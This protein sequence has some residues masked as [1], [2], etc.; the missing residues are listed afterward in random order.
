MD[1]ILLKQEV[2]AH[3]NV[4]LPELPKTQRWQTVR[5]TGYTYE[6]AGFRDFLK[7]LKGQYILVHYDFLEYALP[8]SSYYAQMNPSLTA[9]NLEVLHELIK[10]KGDTEL[11][12]TLIPPLYKLAKPCE[13]T[14]KQLEVV[15][16]I[17]SEVDKQWLKIATLCK[18]GLKEKKVL[19]KSGVLKTKVKRADVLKYLT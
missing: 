13:L 12:A 11:K 19:I 10:D 4:D 7:E 14:E 15:E 9:E 16:S 1:R 2:R 5:I 8:T 6:V 17:E 3:E 18:L